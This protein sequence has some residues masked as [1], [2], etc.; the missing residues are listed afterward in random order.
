MSWLPNQKQEWCPCFHLSETW[1]SLPSGQISGV[2][3]VWLSKIQDLSLLQ[4]TMQPYIYVSGVN[5]R[6]CSVL[7]QLCQGQ[8]CPHLTDM[9]VVWG[10]ENGLSLTLSLQFE[11][12][13]RKS[14]TS[15]LQGW[16]RHYCSCGGNTPSLN[17][18]TRQIG[19]FIWPTGA[20][21]TSSKLPLV[22]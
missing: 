13:T 6:M 3:I 10:T 11:Q 12:H 21:M 15:T 4:I 9:S 18:K 8:F 5:R 19:N 17:S 20:S 7:S 22:F 2:L 14:P 1:R 16:F